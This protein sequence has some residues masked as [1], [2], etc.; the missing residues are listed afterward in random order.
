MEVS[1]YKMA[2]NNITNLHKKS[3]HEVEVKKKNFRWTMGMIEDLINKAKMEYQSLDFDADRPQQIKKV[4]KEMAKK[5]ENGEFG[6]V[7]VTPPK[8]PLTE[9][10]VDGKCIY[11]KN[12]KLENSQIQKGHQR[13]HE[14]IKE[15]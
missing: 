2:A 14:E 10:S 5:Y 6:S 7:T 11:L 12:K 8:K 1:H 3:S 9:L 13:V 4:R 15:I